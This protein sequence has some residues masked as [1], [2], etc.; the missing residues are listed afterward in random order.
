[1]SW[2]V[3]ARGR[4][5]HAEAALAGED[6]LAVVAHDRDGVAGLVHA[7][8]ARRACRWLA[9]TMARAPTAAPAWSRHQGRGSGGDG[10]DARPGRDARR[11]PDRG[12]GRDRGHGDRLPGGAAV[13]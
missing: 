4:S 11:L 12:P 10:D 8:T 7:A 1:M 9:A 2:T 13:A 6:G 5:G 3:T